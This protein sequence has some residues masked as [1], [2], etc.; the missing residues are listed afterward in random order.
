ML[1]KITK[2]SLNEL[3]VLSNNILFRINEIKTIY[4]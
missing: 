3:I 1:I 4:P 2:K